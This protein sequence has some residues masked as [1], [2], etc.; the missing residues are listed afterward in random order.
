MASGQ[1]LL[2]QMLRGRVPPG[3]AT[4]L[5][6]LDGVLCHGAGHDSYS[7]DPECPPDDLWSAESAG[8]L[9]EELE[10]A[11]PHVVITSS[12]QRVL[13]QR[14]LA[15]LFARTGLAAVADAMHAAGVA[16]QA[17]GETRHRA[18]E[19]WLHA[20]YT[21]GP[22]AVL[23]DWLSGTGLRG[24]PLDRAGCVVLCEPGRGL[25]A[26]ERPALALALLGA[27]PGRAALRED[28]R[29]GVLVPA[30]EVPA[31]ARFSLDLGGEAYVPEVLRRL[32]VEFVRELDDVLADRV[33]TERYI[34]LMRRH[35]SVA[36]MTVEQAVAAGR[37]RD[38]L[39][40][41]GVLDRGP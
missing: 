2:A 28:V 33:P 19:R 18:I 27:S 13:D 21:G 38:V 23:D 30:S 41:A 39:W 5:L 1:A 26:A 10:R 16:P 36:G 7:V 22:V 17:D 20:R 37:E 8:V 11:A 12:W 25:S 40:L 24:S 32:P 15:D 6:D 31:P 35:G 14:Q 3:R 29:E 4:L 34:F 9:L